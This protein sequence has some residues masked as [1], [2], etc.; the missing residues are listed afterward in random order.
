MKTVSFSD[1]YEFVEHFVNSYYIAKDAT[2]EDDFFL[3]Y[4]LLHHLPL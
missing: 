2:S 3:A 4:L 1:V